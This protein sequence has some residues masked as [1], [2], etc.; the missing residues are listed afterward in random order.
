[1]EDVLDL[2]QLP[3]DPL[4]PVVCMDELCKELHG[5]VR[6]PLAARPGK[7]KRIDSEYRRQGTANVFLYHPFPTCG[8][9][10]VLPL[11]SVTSFSPSAMTRMI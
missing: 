11:C 2:Y 5:E 10:P 3:Y 9:P 6:E 4:K 7:I 8:S 1:M